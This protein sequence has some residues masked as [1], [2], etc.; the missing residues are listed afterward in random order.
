MTI[1]SPY[2]TARDLEERGIVGEDQ[3]EILRFAAYLRDCGQAWRDLPFRRREEMLAY[4]KGL[5]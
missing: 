5:R 1:I 4:E 3:A 2:V